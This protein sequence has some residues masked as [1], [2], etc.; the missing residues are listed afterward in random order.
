MDLQ[1][2]KQIIEACKKDLKHFNKLYEANII[3]VYRF[4][5]SKVGNKTEAEEIVS[6]TFLKALEKIKSYEFR[7]KPIKSWLFVIARNIIYQS[8]RKPDNLPFEDDWQGNEDEN[9]LDMLANR[10]MIQKVEEFIVKFRPPVPEIIRLRIW[11]EMSFEEIAEVLD[12]K[13][14]TVKMAYY[15]ALEKVQKEFMQEGVQL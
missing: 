9:I 3:P 8:Y 7:A 13:V 15:R 2:E 5:Y 12:K 14:T 6:D 11:E 4:V 1:E 10:E